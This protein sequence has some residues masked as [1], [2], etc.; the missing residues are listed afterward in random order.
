MDL[1]QSQDLFPLLYNKYLKLHDTFLR[2][3]GGTHRLQVEIRKRLS[4]SRS[5]SLPPDKHF[6]PELSDR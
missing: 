5:T 3:S 2:L 4:R 6:A 1:L